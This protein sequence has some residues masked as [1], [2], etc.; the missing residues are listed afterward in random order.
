M[1]KRPPF[2]PLF[3]PSPECR[4]PKVLRCNSD[5]AFVQVA[6]IFRRPL[7]SRKFI[8]RQQLFFSSFLPTRCFFLSVANLIEKHQRFFLKTQHLKWTLQA[9]F[10]AQNKINRQQNFCRKYFRR[11]SFLFY[12]C[13]FLPILASSR[14]LAASHSP[15]LPCL[16]SPAQG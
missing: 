13:F 14:F 16:L 12:E 10:P 3:W 2:W 9:G 11:P 7:I 4:L 1:E 5:G 15:R 8:F 6:L